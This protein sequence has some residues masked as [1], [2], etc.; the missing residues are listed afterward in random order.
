MAIGDACYYCG[1]VESEGVPEFK[2]MGPCPDP[3]QSDAEIY[4]CAVCAVEQCGECGGTGELELEPEDF[5]AGMRPKPCPACSADVVDAEFAL[6]RVRP[7]CE[8]PRLIKCDRCGTDRCPDCCTPADDCPQ[9]GH[10]NKERWECTWCSSDESAYFLD[11]P[12]GLLCEACYVE[13]EQGKS[14]V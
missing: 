3:L 8:C 5:A 1:K 7:P 9:C 14:R 10:R 12:E 4:A 6:T 11:T 13:Y 2:N